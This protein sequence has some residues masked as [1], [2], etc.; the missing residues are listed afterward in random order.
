MKKTLAMFALLSLAACSNTQNSS[1]VNP[2]SMIG[3]AVGALIG[4][5]AGGHFGGGSGHIV[6]ILVGGAVGAAA[7]YSISDQLL[8]SDITRFRSSAKLAMENTGDG[9][10]HSWTNPLTGVAG[11]IKPVLT[12]YAAQD[13]YCRD[14]EATIAIKD[15]IGEASSRACKNSGGLWYLDPK[16]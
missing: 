5:F 14:F 15:D 13:T 6:W 3:T 9:Q 1:T 11:T 8:P 12:Y 10:L 4:G 2:G 16:I 7:G